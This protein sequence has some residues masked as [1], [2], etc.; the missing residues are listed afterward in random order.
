MA[1]IFVVNDVTEYKVS[2]VDGITAIATIFILDPCFVDKKPQ[3]VW[4]LLL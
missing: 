4:R 1:I 3:P 2:P